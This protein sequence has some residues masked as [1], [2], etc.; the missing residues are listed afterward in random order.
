MNCVD[1]CLYDR[2]D[3]VCLELTGSAILDYN[4]IDLASILLTL[5]IRNIIPRVNEKY[6]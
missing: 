1:L 4:I 5:K 2:F 3:S 6:F